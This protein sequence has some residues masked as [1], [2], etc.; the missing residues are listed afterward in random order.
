MPMEK[1]F[2]TGLRNFYSWV[3]GGYACSRLSFCENGFCSGFYDFF[4]RVYH[5]FARNR[6]G[7]DN[8]EVY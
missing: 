5:W 1:S 2:I 6:N 4:L 7:V 8:A 3:F